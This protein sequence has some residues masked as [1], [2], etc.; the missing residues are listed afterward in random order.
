[1][2]DATQRGCYKGISNS[3]LFFAIPTAIF[4]LILTSGCVTSS[5]KKI[6]H[7][8][9]AKIQVGVS[10][11]TDVERLLGKPG[12]VTVGSFGTVLMYHHMKMDMGVDPL[13]PAVHLLAGRTKVKSDSVIVTIGN[14]GK[15]TRVTN[16]NRENT[17]KSGLL[18]ADR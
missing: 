13:I 11:R 12:S 16:G 5:G 2:A 10:T 14:D 1:M 7:D 6:D 9:A 15:V 8:K 17:I 18:N 3:A 4:C